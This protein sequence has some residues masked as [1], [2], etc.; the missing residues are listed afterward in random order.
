MS[1]INIG[2]I[3]MSSSRQSLESLASADAHVE[4]CK[5]SS[6]RGREMTPGKNLVLQEGMKN[7]RNGKYAHKSD[8]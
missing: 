8:S 6:S 1:L 2:K 5:R 3:K 7:M 4:K